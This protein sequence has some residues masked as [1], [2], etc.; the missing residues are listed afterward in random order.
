MHRRMFTEIKEFI[1]SEMTKQL[2]ESMREAAEEEK[3]HAISTGCI[4]HG[5]PA[6]TVVV[7]GGWSKRS[8]KHSYNAKSGVTVIVESYTKKLLFLDV[9]NKFCSVCATYSNQQES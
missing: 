4:H 5:I 8:H 6:I 1:G 9:R 7:D 2:A 3:M